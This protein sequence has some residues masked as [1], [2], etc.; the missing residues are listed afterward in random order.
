VRRK[1]ALLVSVLVVTGA[2]AG[3]GAIVWSNPILLLALPVSPF[4]GPGQLADGTYDCWFQWGVSPSEAVTAEISG[5]RISW[6]G[7]TYDY[8]PMP[9]EDP[10]FG[11]HFGIRETRPDGGFGLREIARKG[12]AYGA[13][14][15][16]LECW[17]PGPRPSLPPK[18]WPRG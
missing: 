18:G 11:P 5:D 14:L 8:G 16:K 6:T 13:G 10:L 12:I 2:A 15:S 3:C 9:S 17:P 1:L 4:T 7:R